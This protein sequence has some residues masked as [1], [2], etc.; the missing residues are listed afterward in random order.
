MFKE[1][2]INSWGHRIKLKKAIAKLTLSEPTDDGIM[3]DENIDVNECE[4]CKA[5]TQHRCRKCSQLVCILYCSTPNPESTNEMHVVHKPGDIRCVG[6][7][8]ECPNC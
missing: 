6:H 5:S 2:G 7:S 3:V 4:L 1:L 8:F